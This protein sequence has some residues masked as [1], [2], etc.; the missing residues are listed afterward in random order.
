MSISIRCPNCRKRI[1]APNA[2]RGKVGTCRSCK[3]RFRLTTELEEAQDYSSVLEQAEDVTESHVSVGRAETTINNEALNLTLMSAVEIGDSQTV[4]SAMERGADPNFQLSNGISVLHNAIAGGYSEIVRIL[5]S[6][7]ANLN[8]ADEGGITPLWVRVAMQ[9]EEC[10]DLLL[11]AGADPNV[12]DIDGGT[13]LSA[14]ITH[15]TRRIA[16]KLIQAGANT[17]GLRGP[18]RIRFGIELTT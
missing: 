18:L 14:A 15:G 7:N 17:K 5:L 4:M 16:E 10:V 1:S 9:Q 3:A 6:R 13:P 8:V 2:A 12:Q 11:D